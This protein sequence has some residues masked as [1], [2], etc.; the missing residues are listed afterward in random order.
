[1]TNASNEVHA[2]DSRQICMPSGRVEGT[3]SVSNTSGRWLSASFRVTGTGVLNIYLD[4]A[5]YGSYAYSAERRDLRI[6]MPSTA[7][8]IKFEYVPGELD[9]GEAIIDPM[10]IAKGTVMVFR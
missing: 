4:D 8:G 10:H 7:F 6:A 1:M 3:V 9:S 2:N 5:L